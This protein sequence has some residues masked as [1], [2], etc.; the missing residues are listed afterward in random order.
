MVPAV[1]TT[2]AAY[3]KSDLSLTTRCCSSDHGCVSGFRVAHG[4]SIIF[5][6]TAERLGDW[7]VSTSGAR[8]GT[9]ATAKPNAVKDFY[10]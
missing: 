7:D 3:L 8:Y 4:A 10:A 5:L 6:A 9:G 2:A 1:V